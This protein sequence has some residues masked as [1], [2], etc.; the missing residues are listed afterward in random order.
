MVTEEDVKTE[1]ASERWIAA[2]FE[3][4]RRGSLEARISKDRDFPMEHPEEPALPTSW[5]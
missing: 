3:N 2:G 1:A 5:F 4:R